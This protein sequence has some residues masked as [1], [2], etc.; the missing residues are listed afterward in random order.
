MQSPPVLKRC[1]TCGVFRSRVPPVGVAS[2]TG[3]IKK[4]Q[5]RGNPKTTG[6]VTRPVALFATRTKCQQNIYLTV[7]GSG[8]FALA[9]ACALRLPY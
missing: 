9:I 4:R 8:A 3:D 1:S 5:D 7:G 6:R 2:P